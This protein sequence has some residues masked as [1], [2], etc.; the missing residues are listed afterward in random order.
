[1]SQ[2]KM[3]A[4]IGGILIL[5]LVLLLVVGNKSLPAITTPDI[6]ST[7]LPGMQVTNAPWK[8]GVENLRERLSAINL[9]ALPQEGSALHIH[10]HLDIYIEGTHVPVPA[11]I[12]IQKVQNF[13]SPIHIHDAT[14]I[15]H[16]ES[17]TVQ[18]FTL[19]QFFNIW[20]VPL[21]Q[22]CIGAYCA[23]DTK[24]LKV[25]VNGILTPGDPRTIALASHQELVITYGTD[26]EQPQPIPASYTFPPGY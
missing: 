26:S 8:S 4:V 10:Q 21:T 6:A 16:V 3:L 23:T 25:Y 12:G 15:I 1:M 5:A 24:S 9:P 19:G 20:G 11:D 2:L 17:P 13:I 18:T 14:G 22:Q 7:T